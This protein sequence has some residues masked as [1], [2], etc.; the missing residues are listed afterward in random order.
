MVVMVVGALVLAGGVAGAL[1]GGVFGG[2]LAGGGTSGLGLAALPDGTR[3]DGPASSGRA[4][5]TGPRAGVPSAASDAARPAAPGGPGS[6]ATSGRTAAPGSSA[7]SRG[8]AAPRQTTSAADALNG[9]AATTA[10]VPGTGTTGPAAIPGATPPQDEG[11]LAIPGTDTA[12]DNRTDGYNVDGYTIDGYRADDYRTDG[13]RADGPSSHTDHRA[14]DYFR[15]HWTPADKAQSRVTD[16]R[17][18]GGYLRI[19]TNLPESARNSRTA[20]VLCERGM[21]YLRAA[22]ATRRVVFVHARLGGNGNPVLANIIGPSDRS[23]T[24]THPAPE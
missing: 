20:V 14:M 17:S 13:Y 21:D 5:G 2:A 19:Y 6:S 3:S 10:P 9:G 15:A 8:T 11:L 23:C 18:V 16:I 4:D 24:L 12:D 7:T 1:A 22:G